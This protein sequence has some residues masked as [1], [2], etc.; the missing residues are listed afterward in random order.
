[1]FRVHKPHA[2][3]PLARRMPHIRALSA[4]VPGLGGAARLCPE[5]GAVP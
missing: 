4:G 3:L 5:L 1:M 2:E